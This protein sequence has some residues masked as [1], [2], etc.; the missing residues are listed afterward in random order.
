[1]RR[2]VLRLLR[3]EH[4]QTII[5]FVMSVSTLM[6]MVGFVLDVGYLYVN[7]RHVQNV[8]DAASLAGANA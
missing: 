8:V 6:A 7:Q 2:L 1:M 5:L 4:G 3:E